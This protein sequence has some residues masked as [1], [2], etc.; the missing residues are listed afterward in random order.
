MLRD[1]ILSFKLPQGVVGVR[2]TLL[3]S[4]EA[5][6][7]ATKAYTELLNAAHE[8]AMRGANWSWESDPDPVHKLCAVLAGMAVILAKTADAVRKGDAFMGRVTLPFIDCAPPPAGVSRLG[9]VASAGDWAVFKISQSGKAR[10]NYRGHAMD[11]FKQAA[12]LFAR[13]VRSR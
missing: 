7:L 13:T 5:N 9:L 4:R 12:L 1:L 6:A 2:R 8:A 3:L 10:V 11:G